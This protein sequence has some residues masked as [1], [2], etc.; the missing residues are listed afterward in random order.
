MG[1]A[2]Q[3]AKGRRHGPLAGRRTSNES[4]RRRRGWRDAG[5]HGP[6]WPRWA[7]RQGAGIGAGRSIGVAACHRAVRRCWRPGKRPAGRIARSRGLGR[8]SFPWQGQGDETVP[9]ETVVGLFRSRAEP[10]SAA[11]SISGRRGFRRG[12]QQAG[13]V[14]MNHCRWT[15][16]VDCMI[17]GSGRRQMGRTI[18][19]GSR[20]MH[21]PANGPAAPWRGLGSTRVSTRTDHDR[22]LS[23]GWRAV[24]GPTDR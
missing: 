10:F 4:L 23:P 2:G 24:T 7:V 3:R 12:T 15:P 21:R 22:D 5:R 6:G 18:R 11:G 16:G 13:Q 17:W 14:P 8:S 20:G 1:C 9:A 19:P